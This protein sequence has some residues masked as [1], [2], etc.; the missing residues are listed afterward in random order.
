MTSHWVGGIRYAARVWWRTPAF[1]LTAVASLAIGIGANTTIFTAASSLLLAPTRG[2]RSADRLVDIGASRHGAGFDTLSYPTYLD[3]RDQATT[4]SGVYAVGIEPQPMS[5]GTTAGAERVYGQLVSASFFDVLGVVPTSGGFFHTAEERPGVPLRKVVLSSRFWHRH[6]NAD[7]SIIGSDIVVNGD[8]FVITGITPDGFQGTTI[9][10][11]DMWVPLTSYAKAMPTDAMMRGRQNVWLIM[12]ARLKDG[13]TIAQARAELTAID[14]RLKTQYPNAYGAMNLVVAPASRVPGEFGEVIVPVIAVLAV[15]VGLVMLIACTNLASLLLARA[16][17]RSRDTAVRLALGATRFDLIAQTLAETLLVFL[18]GGL[19]GVL[20]SVWMSAALRS[21]LPTLP[22]PVDLSLSPDWRVV[23]FAA[24]LSLSTG[25]LTGLMPAWQGSRANVMTMMK[26]DGSARARQRLRY[27]FVAAQM[28]LCLLL[29]VIAGLFLRAVSAAATADPGFRVRNIDIASVDLALGGYAPDRS[30]AITEEIRGRFAAIPGVSAAS[31]AA[32]VPLAGNGLGLGEVRKVGATGSDADIDADWNVISPEFLPLLDLPM[33]RGRNF[34]RTDRADTQLVAVVNEQFAKSAWPGENPIGQRIETGD[35]RK[36]HEADR[37]I[38]TVIGVARDAKY[39]WIGDRARRFL[40][41]PV[42]QQKWQRLNI[43]LSRDARLAPSTDLAP[44]VRAALKSFDPNLPLTDFTTF[45]NVADLG[46]LPQKLSA[47]V[48]GVLGT[49]ALM[50]AAIGIYGVT[51]YAVARRTRE[52][53]IRMAL[54]ADGGSV[55]R[56]VLRQGLIVTI[57]GGA[58]G[59]ALAV[60]VALL[61]SSQGMLFGVRAI[62]PI[63]FGGTTAL[64]IGIALFA[65]YIPAKRA[66]RIDPLVA[67]RID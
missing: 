14:A 7:P 35:F 66:A 29:L 61:L 60:A 27:A 30:A 8:H 43:F 51:T 49:V 31:V 5:L 28:G 19:A 63:S 10:A 57:A 65:S 50:L 32:I 44:A 39:R 11:P 37:Q 36:G 53:G 16:S 3:V 38:L 24:A 20:L 13:V 4:L 67:L 23:G 62:D 47:S 26:A 9:L 55:M 33:V 54:G 40:Y 17:S 22:V 58:V 42:A 64:L 18:G 41:V 12:G 15:V 6:F 56:L 46:L 48:A 34:Q 59:L 52:I 21:L 25:L 1:T 45:Q 2:V